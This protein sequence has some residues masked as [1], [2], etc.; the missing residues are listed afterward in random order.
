MPNINVK[1]QKELSR[2][3]N[4]IKL[5]YFKFNFF[6][7]LQAIVKWKDNLLQFYTQIYDNYFKN[8]YKYVHYILL[9]ILLNIY[10]NF[11]DSLTVSQGRENVQT[12]SEHG[13]NPT[14]K[15]TPNHI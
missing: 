9:Y 4:F 2:S 7:I 1:A 12:I 3:Y 10:E 5:K 8:I 15:T 11:V 6:N 13:I 14:K